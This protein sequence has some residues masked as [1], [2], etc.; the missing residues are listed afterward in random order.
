MAIMA[1]ILNKERIDIN[2]Q[3]M[4]K[5]LNSIVWGPNLYETQK[6]P[7]RH[8]TVCGETFSDKILHKMSRDTTDY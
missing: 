5:R 7:E 6:D 8:C 2:K 4:K 1:G 3:R